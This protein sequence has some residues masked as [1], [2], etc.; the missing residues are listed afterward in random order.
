MEINFGKG[1][2]PGLKFH[3]Q[4]CPAGAKPTAHR[5]PR[6]RPA[7]R[8]T[9]HGQGGSAAAHREQVQRQE[10]GYGS[11]FPAEIIAGAGDVRRGQAIDRIRKTALSQASERRLLREEV[12]ALVERLRKG[13]GEAGKDDALRTAVG[14]H[15]LGRRSEAMEF[16]EQAKESKERRYYQAVCRRELGDFA[17]AVGD[18]EK[19]K[20]RGWDAFAVNMQIV[21][22]R[23][24]AGEL[25]EVEKLLK[26]TAKAGDSQAEWHYQKA[27]LE[28]VEGRHE[29][30]LDELAKAVALD[31]NHR[32]ASFQLAFFHDLRG[33]E[34]EAIKLYRQCVSGPPT[35]VN[36]LINLAVLLEDAGHYDEA[37]RC[38]D[39]VLR[40]FP[41]HPRATLFRKDALQSTTMMFDKEAE[42]GAASATRCWKFP[43]PTSSSRSAAGTASRR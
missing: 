4:M 14:L 8:L 17:K 42:K 7:A 41:E 25:P 11:R 2:M 5:S 33:E 43:S 35:H 34:K 12:D 20:S 3:P 28:E 29:T 13:K 21:E 1:I 19:A 10:G 23:R 16:F 9:G 37:I 31:A 39:Q 6:G 38:L 27:R 18:F 40:A 26:E 24:A 32:E 22:T 15:T 30:A 36:A